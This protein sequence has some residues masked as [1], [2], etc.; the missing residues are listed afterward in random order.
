MWRVTPYVPFG[1]NARKR[2]PRA[3]TCADDAGPPETVAAALNN[4]L[5]DQAYY[6]RM[7]AACMAGREVYCWQ[8][9]EERRCGY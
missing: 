5:N 1:L 6:T 4:M 7:Q 3:P 9:E 8:R 2:S